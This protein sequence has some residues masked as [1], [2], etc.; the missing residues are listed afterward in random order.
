MGIKVV[1]ACHIWE[2]IVIQ[3]ACQSIHARATQLA[4]GLSASDWESP[5]LVSHQD[6]LIAI[7]RRAVSCI[8]CGAANVESA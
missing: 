4:P 1:T 5:L 6:T 8:C 2:A 3:A 7:S